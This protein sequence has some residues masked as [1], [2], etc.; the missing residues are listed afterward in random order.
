MNISDKEL[1]ELSEWKQNAKVKLK[2]Y[3]IAIKELLK[4]VDEA[5]AK[6]EVA[7]SDLKR[8][9]EQLK[10]EK[11]E[12]MKEYLQEQRNW[13]DE[14][15]EEMDQIKQEYEYRLEQNRDIE[16]RLISNEGQIEDLNREISALHDEKSKLLRKWKFEVDM[17][18]QQEIELSVQGC[19]DSMLDIV[20][21][22]DSL[23]NKSKE[24]DQLRKENNELRKSKSTSVRKRI[25]IKSIKRGG[26]LNISN[27][28]IGPNLFKG[29]IKGINKSFKAATDGKKIKLTK[30]KIQNLTNLSVVENKNSSLVRSSEESKIDIRL[31]K[32]KSELVSLKTQRESVKRYLKEYGEEYA[33]EHGVIPTKETNETVKNYIIQIQNLGTLIQ[34]KEAEICKYQDFNLKQIKSRS[35]SPGNGVFSM[36]RRSKCFQNLINIG[37]TQA[38]VDTAYGKEGDTSDNKKEISPYRNGENSFFSNEN[39]LSHINYATNLSHLNSENF[40]DVNVSEL[41]NEP[42]YHAKIQ[43]A[44]DLKTNLEAEKNKKELSLSEDESQSSSMPMQKVRY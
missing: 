12:L 42:N 9:N 28:S 2:N 44:R 33:T 35:V 23:N 21:L 11:A 26:K 41:K 1:N 40:I 27:N 18:K 15:N 10:D 4:Q 5:R 3:K 20:E 8:E 32:L 43:K 34:N 24:I 7:I 19:V 6:H 14:H 25:N 36:I 31:E 13:E 38:D 16:N 37:S 22:K 30:N 29:K 39:D 17:L